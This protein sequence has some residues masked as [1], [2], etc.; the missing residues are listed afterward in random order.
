[1]PIINILKQTLQ[2]LGR[3]LIPRG[4]FRGTLVLQCLVAIL[5]TLDILVLYGIFLSR[6]GILG[7]LE[8]CRQVEELNTRILK[9]REDNHKLFRRIQGFKN[10]PQAQ[11]KQVREQLGWVKENELMIEFVKPSQEKP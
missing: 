9:L 8:Q 5:L 7:Y 2:G 1:M 10:D 11:E 6:Q 3:K 4:I